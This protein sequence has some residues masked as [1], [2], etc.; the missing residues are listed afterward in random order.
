[1]ATQTGTTDKKSKSSK[2]SA[3]L[4]GVRSEF[5]KIVWPT[6]KLLVQYTIVVILMSIVLSLFVYGLDEL[7]RN[8]IQLIIG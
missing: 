5:N 2:A 7:F 6:K 1:M 3:F 8:V 4:K